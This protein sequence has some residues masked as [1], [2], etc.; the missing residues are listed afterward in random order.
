MGARLRRA[1]LRGRPGARRA[2]GEP[3]MPA[4]LPLLHRVP[5]SVEAGRA[6]REQRRSGAGGGW[7]HRPGTARAARG[8]F[9]PTRIQPGADFLL[10]SAG[11]S[12]EPP[13]SSCRAGFLRRF[14]GGASGDREGPREAEPSSESARRVRCHSLRPAPANQTPSACAQPAARLSRPVGSDRQPAVS[15]REPAASFRAAAPASK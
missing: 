3:L 10:E 11:R 14:S 12:R 8:D 6:S 13:P 5:G 4:R 15:G 1:R 7:Q 2:L 9:P